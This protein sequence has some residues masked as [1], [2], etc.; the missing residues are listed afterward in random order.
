[1]ARVVFDSFEPNN[2]CFESPAAKPSGKKIIDECEVIATFHA[3]GSPGYDPQQAPTVYFKRKENLFTLDISPGYSTSVGLLRGLGFQENDP[4][5]QSKI[6]YSIGLSEGLRSL[7]EA[8]KKNRN[9]T[10][11]P[12]PE[13]LV[14]YRNFLIMGI[15][16]SS[17]P[18]SK[19]KNISLAESLITSSK[20]LRD[21]F[22]TLSQSFKDP[23][24]N[25]SR[26]LPEMMP[27]V[28]WLVSLLQCDKE[29]E[30]SLSSLEKASPDLYQTS[31]QWMR[32]LVLYLW[33][34]KGDSQ[35]LFDELNKIDDI[36]REQGNIPAEYK[37]F[38]THL[39]NQLGSFHDLGK[40]TQS[41]NIQ[42]RW[43][44]T[45][46]RLLQE[47]IRYQLNNAAQSGS[48]QIEVEKEL[49]E[50]KISKSWFE[51]KDRIQELTETIFSSCKLSLSPSHHITLSLDFSSLESAFRK[52]V[53]QHGIQEREYH[54]ATLALLRYFKSQ[55]WV[56][57]FNEDE[58]ENESLK[59]VLSKDSM[60]A[61]NAYEQKLLKK[62][63]SSLKKTNIALPW[64]EA[65]ICIVGGSLAATGG[66]IQNRPLTLS[67]STFTGLG[68]GALAVHFIPNRN[69]YITDS[70]GGAIG[71]ALA[72][73]AAWFATSASSSNNLLMGREDK[74]PVSGFGP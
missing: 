68:C 50:A 34:G 9:E 71:A 11:S 10:P 41:P 65:G 49:R 66:G 21:F 26:I 31:I 39:L 6:Y 1:M 61:W 28:E 33:T 37:N 47:D 60:E 48:L 35:T 32:N 51:D 42:R 18:I 58:K 30:K 74:N 23:Q 56:G 4:S 46:K 17:D 22:D 2:A 25:Q 55:S 64:V 27:N 16:D 13:L 43:E 67:G 15:I 36:F 7:Y 44:Q 52:M 69:P 19:S 62:L 24:L 8:Y 5:I 53:A 54:I 38:A 29:L 59:F 3:E 12:L 20:D 14:Q 72:F 73:T 57:K 45:M 40:T 70:L 63:S